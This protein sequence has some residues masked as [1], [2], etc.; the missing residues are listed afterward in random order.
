MMEH[1]GN[2]KIFSDKQQVR[3]MQHTKTLIKQH[4][5]LK[6]IG[7]LVNYYKLTLKKISKY[8]RCFSI[9]KITIKK[10]RTLDEK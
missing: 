3:L 9:S 8:T 2:R 1:N 4:I 5:T 6:M 7:R 10:Y